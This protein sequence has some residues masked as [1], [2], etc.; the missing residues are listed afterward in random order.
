MK[1]IIATLFIFIGI[2]A[3]IVQAVLAINPHATAPAIALGN[4]AAL[5]VLFLMK[6]FRLNVFNVNRDMLPVFGLCAIIAA[7]ALLPSL[8]LQELMPKLPNIA[9][10][11][12]EQMF[13][14]FMGILAISVIAPIVEEVIF[15]GIILKQLLTMQKFHTKYWYAIVISAVLFAL[16]HCNPAQMPHAFLIGILLGW[17]YYHTKSIMPGIIY[18][19]VN[20]TIACIIYHFYPDQEMELVDMFGSNAAVNT[21]VFIS[22][23]LFIVT[24]YITNKRFGAQRQQEEIS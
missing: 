20:N 2:E 9:E 6:Y 14:S 15:R 5:A 16:V 7:T 24:L 23:V 8:K 1:K 11:V 10:D 21:Y 12:F 13:G 4:V 3:V 19:L 18:H 17:L 22:L